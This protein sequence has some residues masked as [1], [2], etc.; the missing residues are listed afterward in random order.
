M[1][2]IRSWRRPPILFIL[3]PTSPLATLDDKSEDRVTPTTPVIPVRTRRPP[4]PLPTLQHLLDAFQTDDHFLAERGKYNI[5]TTPTLD[6]HRVGGG[7]GGWRQQVVDILVVDF[8]IRAPEEILPRG[9]AFDKRKHVLH[10]AGDDAGLVVVA[11]E[12]EGFARGGLSVGEDDGIEAV[13]GGVHMRAGDGGVDRFVWGTSE[14]GV[15]VE[16]RRR[17]AG[18]GVFGERGIEFDGLVG[19]GGGPC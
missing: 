8:E 15:E 1:T 5:T 4:V 18:G 12:G 13:H 2:A 10:G 9:R 3:R 16:R 7:H 19:W 14:D 11:A 6:L 17:G